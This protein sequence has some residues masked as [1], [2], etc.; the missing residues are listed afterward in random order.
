MSDIRKSYEKQFIGAKGPIYQVFSPYRVCPLGA[1]VDHQHGFISGFA[2]DK[3][4]ELAFQPTEDGEIMLKSCDFPGEVRVSILDKTPEKQGDWGDFARGCVWALGQ[5]RQLWRGI[6]GVVCGSL[7]IGGLSSSAA[8]VLCYL[9]ALLSAN[10]QLMEAD[11]LIDVA[12]EAEKDYVGVNVGKLDQS[13][14]VYPRKNHLLFLDTRDQQYELI[15]TPKS[16][17]PFDIM[18][19]YSGLSR[20]LGSGYNNRVDESRAASWYLKAMADLPLSAFTETKL[21]DVPPE[22]FEKYEDQLPEPFR[23]RA[24]HYFGEVARVKQ[25]AQ[26][27]RVGD[28]KGFGR[29]VFESGQSSIDNYETGSEHLVALYQALK[30]AP[31]VYGAR[32]SGAGFKGCCIA[33][34]D[35]AQREACLSFVEEKYLAQF[36]D[37]RGAYSTHVCKSADGVGVQLS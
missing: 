15:E 19:F 13:C 22:V 34:T 5:R 26:L 14:E 31:G 32:F 24:R 36:P 9:Q 12:L 4:V 21:R 10:D 1:H 37:L 33:L 17:D 18:V 23:R 35:P 8:V 29:L 16:M 30:E 2:I 20:Q 7:P 25:G 11:E 3:G 27:Y 6:R 28:I